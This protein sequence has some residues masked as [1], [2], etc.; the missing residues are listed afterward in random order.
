VHQKLKPKTDCIKAAV[1]GLYYRPSSFG[2]HLFEKKRRQFLID[3]EMNPPQY[4][5]EDQSS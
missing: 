1:T 3:E 2:I 5:G 4:F